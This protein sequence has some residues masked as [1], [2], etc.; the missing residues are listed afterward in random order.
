MQLN[1]MS[2]NHK[3][4]T[5]S[6]PNCPV[7]CASPETWKHVL[8]CKHP[9][10]QRVRMTALTH[11]TTQLKLFK[12]YPPLLDFTLNFF[13]NINFESREEPV[14]AHT[15]SHQLFHYA[16]KE[17][18]AIGWDHFARG[19]LTSRWKHLQQVHLQRIE[20][21]DLYALDKWV[22]AFTTAILEFNRT[23]WLERCRILKIENRL[24]FKKR[25]R[26]QD[27]Q[28]CLHLRKHKDLIQYRDQHFLYKP[29]SFFRS[30][31]MDSLTQWREKVCLSLDPVPVKSHRDI[32]SYFHVPDDSQPTICRK[33]KR[34]TT[35]SSPPPRQGV[36]IDFHFTYMFPPS[37]PTI[38][39]DSHEYEFPPSVVTKIQ[40]R[41]AHKNR[42]LTQ[43]SK[44]NMKY[45]QRLRSFFRSTP[46]GPTNSDVTPSA[47]PISLNTSNYVPTK[48][49]LQS[50][51]DD[52]FQSTSP[53]LPDPPSP[54]SIPSTTQQ[55]I[56]SSS[57]PLQQN[58]L[59]I[60]FVS[61]TLSEKPLFRK[62]FQRQRF[63]G[64]HTNTL[65]LSKK[66]YPVKHSRKTY[67]YRKKIRNPKV[68][69]LRTS[70]GLVYRK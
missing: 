17:Q 24:T 16:F 38:H 19:L 64:C 36:L 22:R 14:I 15:L 21:K 45:Q 57:T 27:W 11:M 59:H 3:W 58:P 52:M 69:V 63:K 65:P 41:A 47:Q 9:D 51:I 68:P 62:Y 43:Q 30:A 40:K 61:N 42:T 37:P 23:L 8:V 39:S 1:T 7:C 70:L 67:K 18:Q 53:A 12:T 33:R 49:R 2:I 55:S 4:G 28:L 44:A 6:T 60:T 35:T 48:L 31:H 10:M 20:S 32:R 25:Q 29:G 26:H 34:E 13:K 66:Y 56:P 5:S 50:F 54:Q 46:S